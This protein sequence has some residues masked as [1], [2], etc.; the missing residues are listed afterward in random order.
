VILLSYGY[1]SSSF[2]FRHFMPALA[3]RWRLVAPDF[4][5]F[6][7]SATP[8]PTRFAY[9]AFPLSGSFE[10]IMPSLALFLHSYWKA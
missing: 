8:A 6:G 5:G 4:P 7:Y 2:Q 1:P 10:T 3:D 9:T